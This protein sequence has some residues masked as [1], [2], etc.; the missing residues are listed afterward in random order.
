[1]G[2]RMIF[3][4]V[5]L[6]AILSVPILSAC[7]KPAGNEVGPGQEFTLAGGQSAEITGENLSIKFIRVTSDS[8]CPQGATCIWA[9]EASSLV[10]ITDSESTYAKTLTQPGL[11]EPPKTDFKNYEITFDL[12]P[13]PQ[14]GKEIKSEDY[15]LQLKISRKPA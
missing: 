11:T 13:Y 7:A 2:K 10:E 1:M 14:L 8:R 3:L 15:R 5:T 4:M 6:A 12:K 9:G